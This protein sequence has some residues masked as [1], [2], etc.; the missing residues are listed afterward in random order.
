MRPCPRQTVQKLLEFPVWEGQCFFFEDFMPGFD[1]HPA[2]SSLIFSLQQRPFSPPPQLAFPQASKTLPNSDEFT[3]RHVFCRISRILLVAMRKNFTYSARRL[4]L[5]AILWTWNDST[6]WILSLWLKKIQLLWLNNDLKTAIRHQWQSLTIIRGNRGIRFRFVNRGDWRL[7]KLGC[8]L[9]GSSLPSSNVASALVDFFFRW[10]HKKNPNVEGRNANSCRLQRLFSSHSQPLL[11]R[12]FLIKRSPSRR[13][14]WQSQFWSLCNKGQWLS[15]GPSN[16]FLLHS[17]QY[18]QC[19][20]GA[21]EGALPS[22]YFFPPHILDQ[23]RR[24]SIEEFPSSLWWPLTRNPSRFCCIFLCCAK[25]RS[26]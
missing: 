15:V 26:F 23:Q 13:P 20:K 21:N 16:F 6:S 9:D 18:K 17:A 7:L 24:P 19:K 12:K 11:C 8:L 5:T 4:F 22:F 1:F 2:F 14:T 3:W 25:T 10:S